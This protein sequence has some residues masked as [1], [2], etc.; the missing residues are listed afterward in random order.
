MIRK[1]NLRPWLVDRKW[2]W[3]PAALVWLVMVPFIWAAAT[4]WAEKSSLLS[5][6]GDG[7]QLLTMNVED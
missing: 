6:L 5:A 7:W 2:L 4:L 3:T 1:H